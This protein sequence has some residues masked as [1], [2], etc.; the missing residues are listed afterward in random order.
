MAKID[1]FEAV[2]KGGLRPNRFRLLL[3]LPSGV[4]GDTRALSLMVK[5]SNTPTMETGIVE[6]NYHGKQ[7]KLSGDERASGDWT[8]TVYLNRDGDVATAKKVA[9]Q[10][11]KVSAET[12]DPALFKSTGYLEL[13]EPEE[14]S[15]T[16]VLRWEIQGVWCS[17]SGELALSMDDVD[18]L[19]EFDLILNYDNVVPQH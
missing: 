4:S 8:S 15:D 2:L 9:E 1:E 10:W 13:L 12:K 18:T 11:Q 6:V 16:A 5:A 7:R 3:T 17:N 19:S 14:D